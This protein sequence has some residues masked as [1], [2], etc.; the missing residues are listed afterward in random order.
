MAPFPGWLGGSYLLASPNAACQR[1]LNLYPEALEATDKEV[2]FFKG[3]PGL[4][5]ALLTL[6]TAPIRC[7]LAGGTPLNPADG[8]GGR[9]F[10]VAGS[11]LY[12]VYANGTYT[13]RGDVGDDAVHSPAQLFPAGD[14]LGIIS[15]GQFYI[16]TG[17]GPTKPLPNPY[18]GGANT[19]AITGTTAIRNVQQVTCS[20]GDN[21]N[22]VAV[23][24][25]ITINGVT[26]HVATFIP[27]TTITTIYT[28]EAVTDPSPR[29]FS[30]YAAEP[31]S[32]SLLPSTLAV[33]DQITIN[34]AVYTVSNIATP[35]YRINLKTT[36]GS[37]FNSAYSVFVLNGTVQATGTATLNWISGDK[38]PLY[39]LIG[40][41]LF[42]NGFGNPA[43]NTVV[44]V[45]S[46]STITLNSTTAGTAI[47]NFGIN[48][49]LA[50][51]TGAFLD[52]YF[53]VAPANSKQMQASAPLDGTSWDAADQARKE[54]YPD[55]I[56]C[57]FADHEELYV[58]GESKSEVW[59][60]PGADLNFPFQRNPSA[61][62]SEGIAAPASMCGFLDGVAWIGSGLRG[63]PVAYYAVGF[64]PQ[65]ISTHAIEKVWAG[66]SQIADAVGFGYE[67]DGHEF[68]QIN[69]PSGDQAWVYDRTASLQ[70]G[71]P[72]WHERNSWDPNTAAWHRHRAG[73]HCYV[74]G[75]HW[76]GDWGTTGNYGAGN[77]YE[78]GSSIYKDAGQLITCI[79]TLPHLC[80]NRLR[81]F[82]TKLQ[83][84]LETGGGSA[85]TVL[86]EWSDDGGTT[87]VGGGSA[88]T[89]TL[90]TSKKLDR[91]TFWSLGSADDRV[92]RI[93]VT[94][95]APKALL[96]LYLDTVQGTS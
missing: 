25:I 35:Q 21:F 66:F 48:P 83:L 64:Q 3:T 74:W 45:P 77:I 19:F 54:S 69:F 52:S 95:N 90:S 87:W 47:Y 68:W 43:T 67:M 55:N 16:D 78:M 32:G 5:T 75:K 42:L 94:G 79:R 53:V 62:M 11:K 14:Q 60:A 27:A 92:F 40:Q 30:V 28:R 33:N 49:A 1:T 34:A 58:M 73:F 17:S 36:P 13:L 72:M 85:L 7:L 56:G 57:L 82:F 38:F 63:A 18:T 2:G 61:C 88:F 12:E 39:G 37:Q 80:A 20:G 23:G 51:G 71:K 86:V 89:L 91:A 93:T 41:V 59:A 26:A 96:N 8:S 44:A 6:P 46:D 15:A 70:F 81:Q 4:A 29:T 9:M 50:A 65:R 84:D 10:A 24:D 31:I 76:A 22:G